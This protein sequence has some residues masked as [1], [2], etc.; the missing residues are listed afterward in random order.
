MFCRTVESMEEILSWQR[1]PFSNIKLQASRYL[2]TSMVV[3]VSG[4]GGS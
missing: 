4:G 2:W 1:K 3:A